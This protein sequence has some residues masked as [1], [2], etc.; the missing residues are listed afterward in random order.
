M[1]ERPPAPRPGIIPLRPVG[2]GEILDGAFTAVRRN[3]KATLGI[4]AAVMVICSV[5]VALLAPDTLV[6]SPGF[7][8]GFV[9]APRETQ[10]RPPVSHSSSR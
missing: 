4:S 10:V 8:V 7:S 1:P 5:V 2:V 3:L 6:T 9:V